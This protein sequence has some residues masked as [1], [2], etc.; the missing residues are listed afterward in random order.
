MHSPSQADAPAC[1]PHAAPVLIAL[2]ACRPQ[3]ADARVLAHFGHHLRPGRPRFVLARIS[4]RPHSTSRTPILLLVGLEFG[5][6]WGA[7]ASAHALLPCRR[8]VL[9]VM[10]QLQAPAQVTQNLQPLPAGSTLA[11]TLF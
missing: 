11:S 9:H 2:P 6:P 1:S 4:C 7:G 10:H 3:D 8:R 5:M